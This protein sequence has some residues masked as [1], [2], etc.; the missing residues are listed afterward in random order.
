MKEYSCCNGHQ[1]KSSDSKEKWN[2]KD[3]CPFCHP[4]GFMNKDP[5]R[6]SEKTSKEEAIV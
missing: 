1:F 2:G 5:E 3:V 4:N 6:L